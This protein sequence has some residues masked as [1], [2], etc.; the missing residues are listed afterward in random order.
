MNTFDHY[1]LREWLKIFGLLLCA[2]LGLLFM[3]GLYD[4]FRDLLE[5]RASAGE[6]A[7]Y[8]AVLMPSFFTLVLQIALLLSLLFV[9]GQLHRRNEFLALRSAGVGVMRMTRVI[10]LAGALLCAVM[11]WLNSTLVPWSVEASERL[12]D[13]LKYRWQEKSGQA[14]RAGLIFDVGFDNQRDRR[15]WFINRYSNAQHRAY[16]VSVSELD[17]Q[18]RERERIIAGDG[19][20]NAERK[21]WTFHEGRVQSY[22]PLTGVTM[23]SVPFAT[24]ERAD[25][26]EDPQLISVFD[27]RPVD[28]SFFELQRIMDYFAYEDN[29]KFARYAVRYYGLLADTFVPLIII[30]IAVPFAMS[31]IRVNPAVGVSKSLGLFVLYM[32]LSRLGTQLGSNE[33]IDP[34]LAA[35]VPNLGMA[36]LAVWLVRSMR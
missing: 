31:G 15:I 4:N 28:L 16:G 24:L 32:L 21:A 22:E 30:A 11:V 26:H 23:S 2:M 3:Q 29:P 19:S 18:R 36:A 13:S 8:F 34:I 25:F 7:F 17:P 14:D 10:W 1:L 20:Y 35:W 33:V 27:R 9:L 12:R 5:M 6:V